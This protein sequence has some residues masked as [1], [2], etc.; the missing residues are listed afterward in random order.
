MGTVVFTVLNHLTLLMEVVDNLVP[1][2]PALQEFTLKNK[3]AMSTIHNS[4]KSG[5]SEL[6]F[7]VLTFE[8]LK[9]FKPELWLGPLKLILSL[10]G[11][12]DFKEKP[13]DPHAELIFITKVSKTQYVIL[14]KCQSGKNYFHLTKMYNS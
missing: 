13:Y 5:Q 4:K 9:S 14:S 2:I 6:H 7:R 11:T 10:S 8:R 1:F 12:A 3:Y